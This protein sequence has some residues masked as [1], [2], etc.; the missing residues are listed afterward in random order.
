MDIPQ[1]PSSLVSISDQDAL[2][3]AWTTPQGGCEWITGTIT[4]VL[5]DLETS[6]QGS[7]LDFRIN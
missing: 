2:H 6:P 7:P 4:A 5:I 3:Y 1:E